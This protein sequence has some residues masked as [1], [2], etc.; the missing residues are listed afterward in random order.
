MGDLD[1]FLSLSLFP[2]QFPSLNLSLPLYK[3]GVIIVTTS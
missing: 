1:S 3:M 2:G